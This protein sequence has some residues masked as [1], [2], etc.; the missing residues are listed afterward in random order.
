MN[1]QTIGAVALLL[2]EAVKAGV[3]VKAIMDEANAQGYVS[4]ETWR[5]VRDNV[6]Q[7]NMEWENS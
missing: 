4:D 5:M 6:K 7:A 1:S 3:T 2:S